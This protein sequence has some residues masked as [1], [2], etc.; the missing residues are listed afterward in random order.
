VK[1]G[2]QEPDGEQP[3][4]PPKNSG[5]LLM[6]QRA[7]SKTSDTRMTKKIIDTVFEKS[8][9]PGNKPKTYCSPYYKRQ[10]GRDGF[11]PDIPSSRSATV[12]EALCASKPPASIPIQL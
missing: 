4:D 10:P 6:M 1:N 9:H 8:K 5:A 2:K 11:S 3:K 12:S 7:Y